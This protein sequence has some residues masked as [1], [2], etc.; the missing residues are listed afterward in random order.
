MSVASST[1]QCGAFGSLSGSLL[2]HWDFPNIIMLP[3]VVRRY[4]SERI[5]DRR[6]QQ[7]QFR[8][9][10]Q[11]LWEVKVSILGGIGNFLQV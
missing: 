6:K 10:V 11:N 2:L 5:V 7:K 9:S 1:K 4:Y 8:F 3:S